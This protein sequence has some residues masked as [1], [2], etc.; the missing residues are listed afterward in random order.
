[1]LFMNP[2]PLHPSAF[3][4]HEKLKQFGLN[5][6]ES[7]PYAQDYA[8]W[9]EVVRLGD[10]YIFPE[11]LVDYRGSPNKVT[12]LHRAE[13]IQ[14]DKVTQKKLLLQLLDHV[15]DE[16]ADI[17]YRY[18]LFIYQNLKMTR[19]AFCWYRR[20]IRAN[21]RKGIYNKT[22]FRL[23]VYQILLVRCFPFIQKCREFASSIANQKML[24]GKNI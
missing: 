8:M 4:N 18:S 16:E 5:Y 12:K 6:D 13:Q 24:H 3:F 23:Y 21:N 10:V 11:K 20:L 22:R 17:H 14:C 15:T 9:A 1:M 7:L 19:E 2:G